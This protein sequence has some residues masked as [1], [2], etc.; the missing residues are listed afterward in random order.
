VG[1]GSTTACSRTAEVL[2]DCA[3][4]AGMTAICG[5]TNPEDLALIP[6]T[7]WIVVSQFPPEGEAGSLV[8]FRTTGSRRRVVYPGGPDRGLL[9]A[10]TPQPGWGDPACPGPPDPG[11]FAPHGLDVRG[12]VSG[13][14]VVAV[15]NHG[16]RQAVELFEVGYAAGGPALGW[17]GCVVM[18]DGSWPNDVA[19]WPGGGFAVSDMMKPL[20]GSGATWSGLKLA[21]G[22]DTGRIWRWTPEEGLVAVEGSEGSG[23]NGVAVSA[24]GTEVFFAA[25]GARR[26][27]R[28]RLDGQPRRSEVELAIR[29]D[30]LSWS[31]DGRLLVAGQRGGFGEILACGQVEAGTCAL[32]YAVL[33]VEPSSLEQRVLIENDDEITGA[34]SSALQVGGELF[35]GTFAGDR[36]VRTRYPR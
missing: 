21:L 35:L 11:R 5:F 10:S 36:I 26:L 18:P 32:S 25:W 16:G 14:G 22:A 3:D 30:N 23:P 28:L 33:D 9:G 15:V 24:D 17:R 34:V 8:A 4:G 20:D 31:R 13:A 29:P 6:G 12:D 27:V 19:F 2:T 1:L 7:P